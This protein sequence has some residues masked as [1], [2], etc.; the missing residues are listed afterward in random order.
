MPETKFVTRSR[1]YRA[2]ILST[3]DAVA[4]V[5]AFLI[6]GALRMS[7]DRVPW[8][9]LLV[10]GGICALLHVMVGHF[11]RLHEGRAAIAS[12]YEMVLLGF[13][14]LSVGGLVFVANLFGQW[15]P[16]SIPA[17]AVFTTLV[18]AAWSRAA[19]RWMREQGDARDVRASEGAARV[20][21]I[22]AGEAGREIIGSMLRDP[23]KQ[24][25][26]V[27]LLDD[28]PLKRY[29]RIR[30]V[31][32]LGN[33]DDL[34]AVVA[35]T[36]AEA[37]VVAIPSASAETITDISDRAKRAGVAVKVLPAMP[38]LLKSRPGIRDL[39]DINLH[40]V[41]GRKQLDTDVASI[42][43]YVR[44]KRV[45]VTGAGGSIGSELC[46]QLHQFDPAEL[47]MLDRDESALHA[48]QLSIH[49]RAL[50]DSDEVVLCDIR[51]L[52]ALKTIFAARRPQVVFHAAA[53]KHLPMLEQYPAEALK[54]NIHGTWNVL[55]AAEMVDVERFVNVS[56]DKA[57]NP[58]SVLGY[59]KR[60][61]ERITAAHAEH[62]PGTYLSVRFGNVLG[63]RG[64]VLTAF[65][66]QIAEGGPVTVTDPEVTRF[67]MTIEEACQL[68]IQAGAIGRPGEAL[69]L[70]MGEPIK[71]LDVAHQLIE[72]SGTD[73]PVVF[74]GLRPGEKM[75]EELFADDEPKD[76]RPVH[77]MVSHA[78]VP[79]VY[80]D[81][82]DALPARGERELII[83][84]M[85][86]LCVM[87]PASVA[88]QNALD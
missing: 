17:A 54:T 22:G 12:F 5:G 79:A 73:V 15:V 7:A 1:S 27:A 32:V 2:A 80:P 31:P 67:F 76:V 9:E 77:P 44:G 81:E 28:D 78:P 50:L 69:V 36:R 60:I 86:A 41:L 35:Q 26:P 21:V 53:L 8:L 16:R 63:S 55:Q 49:G 14:T 83:R 33:R 71:I 46:R 29:R 10:V 18:V 84:A 66:K 58:S 43:D 6:F 72:Q 34:D 19:M 51:D 48:V 4:W 3:V 47:M 45:L 24:W 20:V 65:A 37:V 88:E 30:N 75:H 39:R 42:A 13:V 57:A 11:I 74:T 59:S 82:I 64:S 38:E 87:S 23:G 85:A 52:T 40:D 70:D 62:S 25:W 61:A 68:V 56:T